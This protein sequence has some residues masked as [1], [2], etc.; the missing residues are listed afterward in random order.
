MQ[1]TN[2]QSKRILEGLNSL[3]EALEDHDLFRIQ[4]AERHLH[5]LAAIYRLTSNDL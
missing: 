1:E 3:L 4:C 2:G 5:F